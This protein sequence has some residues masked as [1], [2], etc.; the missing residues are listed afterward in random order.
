MVPLTLELLVEDEP[1]GLQSMYEQSS[2]VGVCLRTW[3]PTHIA[4]WFWY[5]VEV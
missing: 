5:L 4:M 3:Q 2:T 1:S